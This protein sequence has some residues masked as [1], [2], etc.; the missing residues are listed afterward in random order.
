MGSEDDKMS[1]GPMELIMIGVICFLPIAL[2]AVTA[3]VVIWV[4]NKKKKTDNN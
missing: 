4:V 2:G 1:I 3:V